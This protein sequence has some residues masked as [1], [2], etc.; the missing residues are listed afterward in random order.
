MLGDYLI[1]FAATLDPNGNG[2]VEWPQYST[3]EPQLLWFN[4]T[5]EDSLSLEPDTY[6]MAGMKYLTTLGLAD[7]F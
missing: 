2:A 3:A 5:T 1:R 4:G 6:R 7:P